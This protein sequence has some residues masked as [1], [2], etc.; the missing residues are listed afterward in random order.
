MLILKRKVLTCYSSKKAPLD[1]HIMIQVLDWKSSQK[2]IS[3]E[4]GSL[5]HFVSLTSHH[6]YLLLGYITDAVYIMSLLAL[7]RRTQ[8][9]T[10]TVI[11]S[12]LTVRWII[13]I[14]FVLAY[15]KHSHVT[16]TTW[17]CNLQKCVHSW[18][19]LQIVCPPYSTVSYNPMQYG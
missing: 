7:A 6:L 5:G 3:R 16:L 2:W 4:A 18:V 1:F 8:A 14:W 17:S 19:L 10:A 12:V 9:V 11:L 13:W 15:S